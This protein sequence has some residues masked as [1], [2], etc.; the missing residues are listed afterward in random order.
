[1]D[2]RSLLDQVLDV[3]KK[4]GAEGDA[5]L[6]ES[7]QLGIRVRDG[8]LET[9]SRADVRGLGVR[10]MK[11]GR[12]G[13][14]HTTTLDADGV[15][16]AAEKALEL[17]RAASPRDDLVLPEPTGPGDGRD[18]GEALALL[19]PALETHSIDEKIDRARAAEAAARAVDARIRRSDGASF[20]E[21]LS[22]SWIASTR[23]LFRHYR[24]SYA[25][26]GVSVI[27]EAEGELQPGDYS[28][29]ATR[30]QDLAAPEEI[31]KRAAE[32]AI[33]LI[34]GRPVPT[35]RY[36]V[37][38]STD[39]GWT[40]L[41]RLAVALNGDHLSKNRSWLAE[42][43]AAAI[44]STLVTIHDDGR[45]RGGLASAPFDGEGVDTRDVTLLDKGKVS[46]M[47]LDLTAAKRM[48]TASNGNSRRGGY[49]GLPEIRS[50]NLTMVPG[51]MAVEELVAPIEK[52]LWIWNLA[53]WW[54]G[55]DPSNPQFSSAAS[56]LWIE[57]G[58]PTSAVAR[59]TVAGSLE[60]ILSG[61]DAV[62][63]DLVWDHA[64][65]TPTFRVRE[66]AVSGT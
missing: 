46:G 47:L 17:A 34:G 18:E 41:L 13:F 39:V 48:G 37:V 32:R 9:I 35:G 26:A 55:M 52:G 50:S 11:D 58:K 4:G 28:F 36:P 23:G 25:Q 65:K 42:R 40:L 24:Q 33:K 57:K 29:E 60:E 12:L 56:G 2:V 10:A 16:P 63:D 27:A 54:I 1:M 66:L 61:V 20:D 49:A 45:R 30:W 51:T 53:G 64:T 14:A 44:G 21:T 19:D 43:G 15:K 5:Y 3:L 8:I 7:R 62:A 22:S 6:E 59:V 38:F 31:G